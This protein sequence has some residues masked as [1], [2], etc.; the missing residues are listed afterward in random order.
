M[1]TT[2]VLLTFDSA[3]NTLYTE[4]VGRTTLGSSERNKHERTPT[5]LKNQAL[6]YRR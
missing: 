5:R 2:P 3:T 6:I 4:N 1:K